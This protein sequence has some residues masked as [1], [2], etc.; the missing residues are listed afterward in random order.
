MLTRGRLCLRL[1]GGVQCPI[2][3]ALRKFRAKHTRSTSYRGDR[4]RDCESRPH[5]NAVQPLNS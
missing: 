5:P 1:R 2:L 4:H 3:G